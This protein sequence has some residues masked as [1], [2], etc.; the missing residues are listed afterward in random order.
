MKREKLEEIKNLLIVVDMVNGFV[1]EGNMADS[2]IEHIIPNIENLVIK[3]INQKNSG[4][5]FIKDN[6]KKRCREF[7]R[8]PEH[9]IDKTKE[10]VLV[11]EL[12]GYEK[13]GYSYLKN[14]T[15]T[16]FAPNF[17]NDIN[18]MKNL[19]EVIV[20]GC[21]TDIC[22]MNLVIPLQNYFDEIN[23]NT[24]ILVLEDAVETYDSP[25]HR[26][27][28]WNRLAFKFMEQSGVKVLRKKMG[29]K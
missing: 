5:F 20:S 21:C 1:R 15:S 3:H 7:M 22:V 27:D 25:N 17:I 8:Y 16:I 2:Y 29:D 9:C 6:H 10:S 18:K 12:R 11:D 24:D 14:S 19:R 4:I 13:Y 23:K 26:R 28:E